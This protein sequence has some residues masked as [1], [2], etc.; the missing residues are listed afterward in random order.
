MSG[1]K[2]IEEAAREMAKEAER[3]ADLGKHDVAQGM[4]SFAAA[5][6][7]MLSAGEISDVVLDE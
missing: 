6:H 4:H 2:I 5:L 3:A 7:G 1:R